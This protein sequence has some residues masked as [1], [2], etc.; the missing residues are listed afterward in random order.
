MI[1]VRCAHCGQTLL[2]IDY[3]KLEI[4]CPRCKEINK[5]EIKDEI[6]SRESTVK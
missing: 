2:I 4:K 1:K 3:G 6:K 5:I